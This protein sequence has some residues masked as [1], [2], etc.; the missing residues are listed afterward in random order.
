MPDVTQVRIDQTL[1]GYL[2]NYGYE[3]Q[4]MVADIIAPREKTTSEQGR[5]KTLGDELLNIHVA[6]AVADEAPT[7]RIDYAVGEDT[8][9]AVERSLK[10]LVTDRQIRQAPNKLAPL[11]RASVHCMHGLK[12]RKEYRLVAT[13]SAT[14]NT[15]TP[16]NDWDA[17]A[18]YPTEDLAVA[19]NT[20]KGNSYG[21]EPTHFVMG[22]HIADEFAGNRNVTDLIKSA[23]ALSQPM[24]ILS[25]ITGKRLPRFIMDME[26][27]VPSARYNTAEPG[28]ALSVSPVWADDAYL[29]TVDPS[30]DNSGYMTQFQELGYTVIRWRSNDPTGWW[31]RVLYRS[32]QKVVNARTVLKIVDVT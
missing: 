16:G 21:I 25:T 13:A 28:A 5:F 6:D 31:I 19:K 14:G 7:N 4:R 27:V 1:T 15:Y 8:Y 26:V 10:I 3:R 29:F 22:D 12:L 20:F 24:Q 23:A 17:A 18:S 2:R 11:Q 30:G 9:L 32:V